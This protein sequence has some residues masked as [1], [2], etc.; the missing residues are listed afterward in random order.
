MWLILN[1][2]T[3]AFWL[4]SSFPARIKHKNDQVLPLTGFPNPVSPS[5]SFADRLSDPESRLHL[6]ALVGFLA[7]RASLY[8]ECQIYIFRVPTKEKN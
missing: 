7:M 6:E 1:R 3:P 5:D 8:A 2:T 4:S